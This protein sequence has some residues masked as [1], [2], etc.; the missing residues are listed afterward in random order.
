MNCD[1]E[2]KK[3]SDTQDRVGVEEPQYSNHWLAVVQLVLCEMAYCLE[4]IKDFKCVQSLIFWLQPFLVCI[5]LCNNHFTMRL[6][7]F[8]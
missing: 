4:A 1:L 5:V 7:I 8:Q 3:K 6:V 2:K